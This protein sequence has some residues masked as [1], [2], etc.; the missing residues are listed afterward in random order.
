MRPTFRSP[1]KRLIQARALSDNWEASKPTHLYEE[2]SVLA[3]AKFLHE[4]NSLDG[5]QH[6][7]YMALHPV[8]GEVHYLA[9]AVDVFSPQGQNRYQSTFGQAYRPPED[10]PVGAAAKDRA[11]VKA[12]ILG[13]APPEH[14]AH[15][16]CLSEEA[17]RLYENLA[18]DVR[19][20]LTSRAWIHNYVLGDTIAVNSSAND[21]ERLCMLAVYKH[22]YQG[23]ENLMLLEKHDDFVEKM[24]KQVREDM[25]SQASLGMATMPMNSHTIPELVTGYNQ[26]DK[27]ERE[28]T[29]KEG[30]ANDGGFGADTDTQE[31]VMTALKD[32]GFAVHDDGV[33]SEELGEEEHQ[34][35]EAF[36]R[37]LA[38]VVREMQLEEVPS[39]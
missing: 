24:R 26:W 36:A 13:D 17:I 28:L 4:L 18:F 16:L 39:A 6:D 1:A 3:Y 8:M 11:V 34:G 31:G 30:Q 15:L 35:D 9:S 7:R 10:L 12:L 23:L 25:A 19:D 29:I 32:V 5:H 33:D 37:A 21:F 20:K 27:T 14:I 38:E 2:K 22:G